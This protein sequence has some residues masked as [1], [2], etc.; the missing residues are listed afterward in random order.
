[1]KFYTFELDDE[2]AELHALDPAS[3][4]PFTA[5]DAR[6]WINLRRV[7]SGVSGVFAF[8]ET[9]RKSNRDD[10]IVGLIFRAEKSFSKWPDSVKQQ[11]LDCRPGL[12]EALKEKRL[13]RSAIREAML[14]DPSNPNLVE[15]SWNA[16]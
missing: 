9:T 4:F 15:P 3:K 11:Y 13:L 12:V 1:M 6:Y 7:E 16:K 8:C 5:A 2:S 14:A 10:L